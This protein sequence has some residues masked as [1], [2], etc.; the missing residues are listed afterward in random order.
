MKKQLPLGNSSQRPA[1]VT[2]LV[3]AGIISLGFFFV[4][5]ACAQDDPALNA[6]ARN[7]AL[8]YHQAFWQYPRLT[9]AFPDTKHLL[10]I[11]EKIRGGEF[12]DDA[13]RYFEVTEFH[14]K[15]LHKGAAQT[16]CVWGGG[17]SDFI[18]ED[19]AYTLNLSRCQSLGRLAM[20]RY[21]YRVSQ[22]Q[23][24]EARDDFRATWRLG[25][26]CQGTRKTI[27]GL[28]VKSA[29]HRPA[30]DC[31]AKCLPQLDP[32]ALQDLADFWRTEREPFRWDAGE[33][34]AAEAGYV[35]DAVVRRA[36][37][38]TTP[39]DIAEL[40]SWMQRVGFNL[41]C[42]LFESADTPTQFVQAMTTVENYLKRAAK[43][44]AVRDHKAFEAA[45]DSF[46]REFNDQ[47][48]GASSWV[49]A[50]T[51]EKYYLRF[52]AYE[53]EVAMFDAA[54]EVLRHGPETALAATKDPFNGQAFGYQKTRDGFVLESALARRNGKPVRLTVGYG[55][56]ANAKR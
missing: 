43:V 31:A 47:P 3:S 38:S 33:H 2:R 17:I 45:L 54:L 27:I 7:A 37:S 13:R 28:I 56:S 22:R 50:P 39:E 32:E 6:L 41:D 20:E 19:S 9:D 11:Q 34:L 36:E 12:D 4:C 5:T 55:A 18:E 51:L 42:P 29:I 53:I 1:P 35:V 16:W 24:A 10:A 23:F 49:S 14:L 30:M 21:A 8:Y 26:H 25:N 44:L 48:V 40:K 52:K 46:R 15:S